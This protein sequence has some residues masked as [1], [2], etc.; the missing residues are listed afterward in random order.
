[1]STLAALQTRLAQLRLTGM[2]DAIVARC[3]AARV[4]SQDPYDL[5]LALLEDEQTRRDSEAVNGRVR[6][7]HFEDVCDFR[8]FDWLFNPQLP[9]ARL[10]ELAH[11]Q[12][13][14]EHTAILLCGPTG[15][16]KTF[17]AQ[18]LGLAAARQGRRVLF[19][20]TNAYLGGHRRRAGRW[21]LATSAET[22]PDARARYPRR[23][24][25][26]GAVDAPARGRPV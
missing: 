14:S 19:T 10:L 26:H 5:I 17:V 13:L 12:Y 22:Q 7:A 3:E 20:K 11:G 6:A 25:L 4:T 18:A 2:L 24:R 15:V 16:G 8:D 1:M 21:K 9:K 23:L